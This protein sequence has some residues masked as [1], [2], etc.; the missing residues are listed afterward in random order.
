MKHTKIIMPALLAVVAALAFSMP[1]RAGGRSKPG[2]SKGPKTTRPVLGSPKAKV[3]IE[4]YGDMQCPYTK[5]L[6]TQV[7]PRLVKAYPN[8]VQVI[9]RDN[10]LAFHKGA[11]PAAM[12]GRE[13][14]L[15]GGS[16]AFYA[17]QKLVF[18]NMRAIDA[19][20]LAAWAKQAGANSAKVTAALGRNAHRAWI[21]K[22]QQ[23][24][25]SRGIRGT[26]ASFINGQKLRGAQPYH[27]FKAIVDSL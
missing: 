25:K 4:V 19:T 21:T 18:A 23:S 22:D 2:T 6:M 20:N 26:P 9:W 24:A 14:F 27:K 12:A 13:V 1:V 17:F 16:K 3:K 15:R 7:I 8:K 5:R 10:P 11:L